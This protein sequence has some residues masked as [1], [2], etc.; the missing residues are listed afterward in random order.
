[1]EMFVEA[2]VPMPKGGDTAQFEQGLKDARDVKAVAIRSACLGTRRYETFKTLDAWKQH[3]AESIQS[4]EAALPLLD[5]YKIPLGIENHKDWT[6]DE[7]AALMQKYSTE[8]F[9]VCLDFGNNISLLDDPMTVIE[10]LAPYAVCSHLKDMAVEGSDDGFLLSEV[11][12]GNGFIDLPRAISLVR[13]SRPDARFSLEMITRDPLKV[14]CLDDLYWA[15]FPD[16]SGLYLA[17]T[18]RFVQQHQPFSSLPRVSQLPNDKQRHLEDQ[19]VI[20]CLKY[21][22]ENLG[23]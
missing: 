18:L 15:S 5:K 6:A 7:L 12:L 9:G 13:R 8:Y 3:V 2:M 1:L 23:V 11:L 19:N 21:A 22:H 4:I 14:P 16:R 17:R 10:K 20:A